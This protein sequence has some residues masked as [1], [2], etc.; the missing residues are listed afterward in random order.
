MDATA[1]KQIQHTIP[2]F[3]KQLEKTNFP[4]ALVPADMKLESLEKFQQHRNQYR[5]T[6]TTSL[7]DDFAAYVKH[8]Q[9]ST[10][11]LDVEERKATVIFDLGNHDDPGHCLH[12]ANLA[13]AITPEF[14]AL[15]RQNGSTDAQR[16]FIEFLEDW[17]DFWTALDEKGDDI[18]QPKAFAALR[19]M[20][21][22][23]LTKVSSEVD[24]MADRRT[25]MES[26][27]AKSAGVQVRRFRFTL[28]PYEGFEPQQIECRL[29][30]R[31]GN[32]LALG[33]SIIGLGHLDKRLS[34]EFQRIVEGALPD[35]QVFKGSH[36]SQ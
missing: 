25:A 9:G 30:F 29:T 8:H 11:F 5:A 21:V 20:S 17:R 32:G 6:F 2:E 10:C 35:I 23:N 19:S 1:I 34:E 3:I 36:S 31:V 26:I 7:V 12:R 16:T 13:P 14:D 18:G 15:Q 24:D 28:I 27:E 4:A 33:L 22:E